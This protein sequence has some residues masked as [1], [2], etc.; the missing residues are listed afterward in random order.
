MSPTIR[1]TLH[2]AYWPRGI[3]SSSLAKLLVAGLRREEWQWRRWEG[4]FLSR[5][6]WGGGGRGGWHLLAVRVHL[7][8]A[9]I[10]TK[11]WEWAGGNISYG[12]QYKCMLWGHQ[13]QLLQLPPFYRPRTP[14][15]LA[16]IAQNGL[17]IGSFHLF[18][19]PTCDTCAVQLT[20]FPVR[21]LSITRTASNLLGP[22][23][24]GKM[25]GR[26]MRPSCP[27][28]NVCFSMLLPG[29]DPLA[30]SPPL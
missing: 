21:R 16:K 5:G 3:L 1:Y 10:K 8:P 9:V 27:P 6:I 29:T 28:G 25:L 7:D 13:K 11:Y 18:V 30:S 15:L 24:A 12:A 14:S 23:F 26:E 2:F 19:H 17:K 22:P 4:G 20:W